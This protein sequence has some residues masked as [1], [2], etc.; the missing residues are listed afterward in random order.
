MKNFISFLK[1]NELYFKSLIKV[2]LVYALIYLLVVVHI[3][4]ARLKKLQKV[5]LHY[6]LKEKN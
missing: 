1:Q 6:I 3:L 2:V 5:V 4:E